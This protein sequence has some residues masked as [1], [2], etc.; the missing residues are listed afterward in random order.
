MAHYM[1]IGIDDEVYEIKVRFEDIY[2]K[3]CRCGKR[4]YGSYYFETEAEM[5]RRENAEVEPQLLCLECREE[6]EKLELMRRKQTWE[7]QKE[8]Q[9]GQGG[10]KIVLAPEAEALGE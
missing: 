5:R 6:E 2:Y 4:Q 10:A 7:E 8:A 1:E 3:C 9:E